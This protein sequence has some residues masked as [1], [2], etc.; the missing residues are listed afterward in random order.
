[1]IDELEEKPGE[2][3]N[4]QQYIGVIRRHY[5]LF[6]IS[7][8][9]GWLVFWSASW[10]L[11][12]RYTWGTQIRVPTAYAPPDDDLPGRLQSISQQILSSTRLLPTVDQLNLYPEDRGRLTPDKLAE[13]MRNDIKIEQV[14]GDERQVTSVNIYYSAYDPDVARQVTGEL[15]HLFTSEY[16]RIL[17]KESE[18][19]AKFLEDQLGISHQNLVEQEGKVR[20]FKDQHPELGSNLQILAK[21]RSELQ[22]REDALNTALKQD[23]NPLEQPVSPKPGDGTPIGAL[24]EELNK[25]KAQRDDL[26]SRGYT[27]RHPDVRKL[28]GL[29]AEK[30][31]SLT[32]LEAAAPSSAS[33]RPSGA[34]PP[35]VDRREREIAALKAKINHYQELL[36]QEPALEQQFADLTRG[37]DQLKAHYDDLLNKKAASEMVINQ[38]KRHPGELL[39]TIDL[40]RLPLK[41]DFPN[42]IKLC[43]IGLGIGL[44]LGT[45]LTGGAEYLDDRIQDEKALE[46]LLPV[47]VLSEIPVITTQA[48]KRRHQRSLRLTWALTGFVFATILAGSTISFLWG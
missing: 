8:F 33:G 48:E 27:D 37:Y 44:A 35:D 23:A 9:L 4:L 11:R 22:N 36:N 32:D 34:T 20:V 29:I 3:L 12:E 21:L 19:K 16:E 30:E 42:R 28:T 41:P 38:L 31:R 1:M 10:V 15:T 6:L 39:L 13:R 5:R 17:I 47:P 25:L 40:T 14:R 18:D 46:E 2:R 7:F 26:K 45:L 43:G 24:E